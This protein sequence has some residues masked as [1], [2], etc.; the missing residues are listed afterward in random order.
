MGSV[1][2]NRLHNLATKTPDFIPG[3]K[4]VG[5]GSKEI[6]LSPLPYANKFIQRKDTITLD[7]LQDEILTFDVGTK[8]FIIDR[9]FV[10][11]GTDAFHNEPVLTKF[12]LRVTERNDCLAADNRAIIGTMYNWANPTGAIEINNTLFDGNDD[13]NNDTILVENGT[14]GSFPEHFLY[15]LDVSAFSEIATE[16]EYLRFKSFPDSLRIQFETN[17]VNDYETLDNVRQC[18]EF[19]PSGVY[20]NADG[21]L[22]V[23]I[24]NLSGILELREFI[25]Q[26][27]TTKL[28]S[29]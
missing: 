3:L 4:G 8:P 17:L 24:I 6:V 23:K 16:F 11:S 14:G 20:W 18:A 22:Y 21:L 25:I 13:D 12:K 26:I 29:L 1:N 7:H 9:I 28:V 10:Y 19:F 2:T 15:R 5:S 27:E